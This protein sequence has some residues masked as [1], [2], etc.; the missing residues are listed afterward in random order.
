M[1]SFKVHCI[2]LISFSALHCTVIATSE[3]QTI[4]NVVDSNAFENHPASGAAEDAGLLK[5]ALKHSDTGSLHQQAQAAKNANKNDPDAAERK[6]RAAE[7]LHAAVNAM[8]T[9]SNLMEEAVLVLRNTSTTVEDK[10]AALEALTVLVEPIDNANYL[11]EILNATLEINRL[12]ASTPLLEA[13]A[14]RLIGVA[15]SN[16]AFFCN[17]L[18]QRHPDAILRL[19]Q[20]LS[21]STDDTVAAAA[22]YAAGQLLRNSGQA[23]SLWNPEVLITVIRGGKHISERSRKKA[24]ALAEDLIL[25]D[26]NNDEIHGDDGGCKIFSGRDSLVSALLD[27]LEEQSKNG[28]AS[29]NGKKMDVDLVEKALFALQTAAA[30]QKNIN[31]GGGDEKSSGNDDRSERV[32]GNLV[33]IFRQGDGNGKLSEYERD[34]IALA[35]QLLGNIKSSQHH[36]EL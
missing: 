3:N 28:D 14:A 7:L 11:L 19:T 1:P 36:D 9:E 25:L 27:V 22:M 26:Y 21:A 18:T 33:E 13:A 16:N 8:P 23:R 10:R 6:A 4:P 5:W 17:G 24:L 34:V 29:S 31:S 32:I 30:Q 2:L 12:L 15:A 35:E 20:L